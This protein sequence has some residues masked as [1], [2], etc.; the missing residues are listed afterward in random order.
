MGVACPED[1]CAAHEDR[2]AR[3]TSKLGN[4]IPAHVSRKR[5]AAR[6]YNEINENGTYSEAVAMLPTDRVRTRQATGLTQAAVAEH[7]GIPEAVVIAA[8]RKRNFSLN[9]PA[10]R[11][12]EWLLAERDM[13]AARRAV[14]HEFDRSGPPNRAVCSCGLYRKEHVAVHSLP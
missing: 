6:R 8:E 2:D 5:I 13:Q 9:L 12:A 11:Y 4:V 14:P 1:F 7:L 3:C 10:I